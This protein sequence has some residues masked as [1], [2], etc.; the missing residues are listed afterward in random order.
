MTTNMAVETETE[1]DVFFGVVDFAVAATYTPSGG[2]P[3]TVNGIFDNEFF[4]ADAGGMVGVAIQQ[5]RF[6]CSASS[7]SGALEGDTIVINSV[8]YVIRVVQPDGTGITTLVLEE[9]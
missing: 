4:E 6:D 8:N 5:P 1:L 9:V 7:V 3:V 2:S